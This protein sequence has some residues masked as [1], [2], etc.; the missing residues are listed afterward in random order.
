MVGTD[1]ALFRALQELE[2]G[3]AR[4][5][6]L[7]LRWCAGGYIDQLKR[8]A[9]AFLSPGKLLAVIEQGLERSPMPLTAELSAGRWRRPVLVLVGD[10]TVGGGELIAAAMQDGGYVVAGQRTFGKGTT[11]RPLL[12]GT[13]PGLVYKATTGFTLRP[14]GV[15]RHRFPDSKPTDPWG[16]RPDRGFAIPLGPELTE[17]LGER[18]EA[19][20]VKGSHD[21]AAVGHD[22]LADPQLAVALKLFKERLANK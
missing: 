14:T 22:P 2:R 15:N 8:V 10:Q 20:A 16:V 3:D 9:S 5:L 12:V 4:G 17:R 11:V 7:D 21:P 6:I 19:D 1:V 13:I 18:Y